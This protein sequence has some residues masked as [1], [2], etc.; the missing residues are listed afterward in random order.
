MQHPWASDR[1]YDEA[2]YVAAGPFIT[3]TAMVA[4]VEVPRAQVL[5]PLFARVTTT[6][7]AEFGTEPLGVQVDANDD[8]VFRVTAGVVELVAKPEGSRTTM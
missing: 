6:M 7:F 2:P 5:D 8:G 3:V 1:E 4:A